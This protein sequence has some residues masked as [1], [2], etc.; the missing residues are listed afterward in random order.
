MGL[1]GDSRT[2]ISLENADP[3]R[4]DSSLLRLPTEPPGQ[5]FLW[6]YDNQAGTALDGI[7]QHVHLFRFHEA[8][9]QDDHVRRAEVRQRLF[10]HVHHPEP[11][12]ALGFQYLVYEP[13]VNVFI[14]TGPN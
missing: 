14:L 6:M 13:A 5:I 10:V 1:D 9:G 7:R 8:P 2:G 11:V 3:T 4:M 12:Q